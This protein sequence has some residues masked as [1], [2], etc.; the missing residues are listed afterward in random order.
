[1]KDYIMMQ[2][3]S[4]AIALIT[5]KNYAMQISVCYSINKRESNKDG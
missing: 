4:I 5:N 1:M 3:N 2:N